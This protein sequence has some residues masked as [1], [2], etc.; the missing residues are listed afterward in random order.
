MIAL[1]LAP[2]VVLANRK[3][4][5]LC[6]CEHNRKK[7]LFSNTPNGARTNAVFYSLFVSAKEKRLVPFEHL[8]RI[9]T[10]APNGAK[11]R[12]LLPWSSDL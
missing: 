4:L 12:D 6:S 5:R 3:F 7:W 11:V 8:T 2:L 1:A 10:Q 9:F